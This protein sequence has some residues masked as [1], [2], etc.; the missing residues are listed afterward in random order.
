M[1][2]GVQHGGRVPP[3]GFPWALSPLA[4]GAPSCPDTT[5]GLRGHICVAP[6]QQRAP[7]APPP[8]ASWVARGTRGDTPS[9][10]RSQ[11][12][13]LPHNALVN[14]KFLRFFYYC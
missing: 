10:D 7:R 6:H 13:S 2:G 5:P 14:V 4:R 12:S 11:L 8:S 1:L 3:L 9:K